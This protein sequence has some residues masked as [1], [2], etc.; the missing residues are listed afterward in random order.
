VWPLAQGRPI[1]LDVRVNAEPPE[2]YSQGDARK[3]DEDR[4][5]LLLK[6]VRDVKPQA[7]QDFLET[8]E[9][10]VAHAMEHT[11]G[12]MLGS[13]PLQF[14][15][16]RIST[17]GENMTQLMYSIMMTGYKIRNAQYRFQL[18]KCLRL[19]PSNQGD[20][21]GLTDE[22]YAS[23]AQ[24][25]KVQGEVVRWH[26]ETGAESMSAVQYMEQLEDELKMLRS[27][28]QEKRT[29][30]QNDLLEYIKSLEPEELTKDIGDE[31]F[32][33]MSVFIRRLMGATE[34][35]ELQPT[36]CNI[37]LIDIARLLYWLIV[38]G[39]TLR[40]SEVRFDMNM[41]FE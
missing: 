29:E 25:T 6:Y 7:V 16:V 20:G 31:V 38:V 28:L 30:T 41:D 1:T 27:Q 21:G 23:R 34:G 8:A 24:K 19:L 35:T 4:W 3:R 18:Q 40:E 32:L 10:E 39:Y 11:V 22:P 26:H 12:S 2:R 9:P 37:E 13:L 5:E 33:A 14:F 36:S 17:I 15:D